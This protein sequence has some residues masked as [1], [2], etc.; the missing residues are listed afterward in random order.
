MWH[1]S[2]GYF[3][4]S[5]DPNSQ[6]Q[7]VHMSLSLQANGIHELRLDALQK[8]I[9]DARFWDSEIQKEGGILGWGFLEKWQSSWPWRC[10]TSKNCFCWTSARFGV[11]QALAACLQGRQT[12]RD[13]CN[14][15][16]VF[17]VYPPWWWYID[18]GDGD[19]H[20]DDDDHHHHD[21]DDDSDLYSWFVM[22]SSNNMTI[23][24]CPTLSD[25]YQSPLI[26]FVG[27]KCTHLAGSLWWGAVR[28]WPTRVFEVLIYI[29]ISI[30]NPSDLELTVLPKWAHF[31]LMKQKFGIIHP[32]ITFIF[33]QFSSTPL[34]CFRSHL[35][36]WGSI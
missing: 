25:L 23:Q 26:H 29:Y 3:R 8:D 21:D 7:D 17:E 22:I 14:A 24:Q 6:C 20:D 11:D 1:A 27:R 33:Q 30:K 2:N 15:G 28:L 4:P 32:A 12:G 9:K 35:W 19:D 16:R 18:H 5:K 10:C 13:I 31:I 36:I 34:F